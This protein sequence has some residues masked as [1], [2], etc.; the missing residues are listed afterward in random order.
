MR[1]HVFHIATA[2][3]LLQ[4]CGFGHP[5]DL[6]K[7]PRPL[8]LDI[9]GSIETAASSGCRVVPSERRIQI[10]DPT[11]S[12]A[13]APEMLG[14]IKVEASGN[15]DR[16]LDDAI[17]DGAE[18]VE[19]DANSFTAFYPTRFESFLDDAR[20]RIDIDAVEGRWS[21]TQNRVIPGI[22]GRKLDV[23]AAVTNFRKA[24]E[25]GADK[26]ELKTDEIPALSSD[27]TSIGDFKPTVL[28]GA[29]RTEFSKS[30]NRT[31]NVKLASSFIDGI[32]LMP[33][34]QFS[35]NEWVGERSEA[36][37]FKEAPVIEQ[38][39][40]VEGLGGGACQVSSTVHAAALIAG[41]GI[42]ERYN[43]SL[44]SSYIPVG[45]DA[46]VSYPL[47][48][49]KVR[50]TLKRPVVLRVHTED[51][52]LIAEFFSDEPNPAK[53][54][55]RREV[56]ET[57]PFKE[58]ITVDTALESGTIKIK[59]R[60]KVGYKVQR[61]RIFLENGKERFEKLLMDTYQPQTQLVSIAFDAI[62]PPPEEA[63]PP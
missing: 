25:T 7:G 40:L 62:Y 20:E 33:G 29:Y 28:I 48:D 54:M 38:G 55:F 32:F 31:I 13:Y 16:C 44:P 49:L 30:K 41:L 26:F 23:P 9:A 46:V 4:A 19:K 15:I 50:N 42:D 36:R 59:K 14:L 58:T 24:I 63:A 51:T 52:T 2:S 56:A 12:V 22:S 17:R 27:L 3:L 10:A 21:Q 47:L 35:Y 6:A 5:D 61:G 18:I 60:G 11:R 45:M 43:H 8:S 34:A 39:Q 1:I 37:G 53:V 57:V